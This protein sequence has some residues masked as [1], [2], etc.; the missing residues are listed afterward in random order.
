MHDK[1]LIWIIS[2]Y[3]T[4]QRLPLLEDEDLAG[5]TPGKASLMGREAIKEMSR[6]TLRA[7]SRAAARTPASRMP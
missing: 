1:L 2:T 3:L 6:K 5:S 7:R 4:L